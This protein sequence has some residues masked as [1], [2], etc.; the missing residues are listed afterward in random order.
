MRAI[1]A[2][3]DRE[4]VAAIGARLQ[5]VA[6]THDVRIAWAIESGSRAWG[7]PSPDSDYD[8]R[9]LYVRRPEAYLSLW[10]TRDVIETPLDRIFDVNGWDLAKAVRLIAKGNAAAIEWLRS[11]IVYD[12]DEG[13]RDRLLALAGE[14]VEREL[15]G[16]HYLHVARQ[17]L[18]LANGSGSLKR[19]FYVLR[20]AAALRWLGDHPDA[21]IPPMDLPTLLDDSEV[22]DGI[23]RATRQLIDLKAVTREMG[24]GRPPRILADF[25]TAEVER[26][27]H[28]DDGAAGQHESVAR[29]RAVADAWFRAELERQHA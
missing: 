7:F 8:C 4:I 29:A 25:A 26:A 15:I 23:R 18:K 13:F 6:G 5:D 22:G 9:F 16:R 10:K 1:P 20:P 21:V 19:F 3:L 14:V 28:F 12:G 11:P 2:S 24:N 27:A 17:Q